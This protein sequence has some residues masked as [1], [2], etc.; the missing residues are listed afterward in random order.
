MSAVKERYQN[1]DA[2]QNHE[3][4]LFIFGLAFQARWCHDMQLGNAYKAEKVDGVFQKIAAW[5][6]VLSTLALFC[7]KSWCLQFPQKL[8]KLCPVGLG[9]GELAMLS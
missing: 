9:H 7:N 2:G 8:V 6:L 3:W 4:Q 5:T 1:A